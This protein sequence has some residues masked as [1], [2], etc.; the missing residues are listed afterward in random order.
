MNKLGL[1]DL[2]LTFKT[3]G[4]LPIILEELIVKYTIEYTKEKP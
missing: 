3:S 4:K 1:K 2:W